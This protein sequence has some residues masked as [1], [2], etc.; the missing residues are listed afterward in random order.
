MI[1]AH[2]PEHQLTIQEMGSLGMKLYEQRKF[3]EA[4]P[5]LQKAYDGIKALR[6]DSSLETLRI[7]AVLAD[8]KA[9]KGELNHSEVMFRVTLDGIQR[10]LGEESTEYLNLALKFTIL[11]N[12]KDNYVEAATFGRK[13]FE[14]FAR[15]HGYSHQSSLNSLLVYT[16]SLVNSGLPG[17]IHEALA[18]LRHMKDENIKAY[19]VDSDQVKHIESAVVDIQKLANS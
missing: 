7:L 8:V 18:L 19:G 15:T 10:S 14:T 4:E 9:T 1:K 12:T 13:V 3:D 6:G 16:E 11:L 2:G 5:L 17:T